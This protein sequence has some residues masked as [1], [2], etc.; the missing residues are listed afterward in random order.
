MSLSK[1]VLELAISQVRAILDIEQRVATEISKY[2]AAAT[3]QAKELC[4]SPQQLQKLIN[5][6]DK[7]D[8][9]LISVA[10][11]SNSQLQTNESLSSIIETTQAVILALKLLAAPNATTTVGVTNTSSDIL[12]TVSD[13][14]DI[15]EAVVNTS[16]V[17]L[18]TITS[19]TVA[20]QGLFRQLNIIINFC[21]DSDSEEEDVISTEDNQI[22]DQAPAPTL[23]QNY[24][25]FKLDIVNIKNFEDNLVRRQAVA[26]YPNGTVAFRS[27]KSF[28]TSDEVLLEQVKIQ[29]DRSITPQGDTV[30][31]I[32]TS[33]IETTLQRSADVANIR[34]YNKQVIK[35]IELKI[36]SIN[37]ELNEE[38]IPKIESFVR[39]R[40]RLKNQPRSRQNQTLLGRVENRIQDFLN[41]GRKLI[42]ERRRLRAEITRLANF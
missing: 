29:I 5:L 27:S 1:V 9:V 21:S 2:Q 14:V 38:V 10:R 4:P 3:Q 40:E 6:R 33:T 17:L 7:I 24:R 20:L 35:R 15:A 12:K 26:L 16:T 39:Q 13:K 11:K 37:K 23:P 18:T 8:L 28:A 41:E 32:I 31:G 19:M 42:A 36:E 34:K 25:D 22:Q 30:D